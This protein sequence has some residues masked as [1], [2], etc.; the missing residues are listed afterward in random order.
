MVA[1]GIR[2]RFN[3]DLDAQIE[4]VQRANYERWA[5]LDRERLRFSVAWYHAASGQ[6]LEVEI[7]RFGHKVTFTSYPDIPK[8]KFTG[9]VLT[10]KQTG[11]DYIIEVGFIADGL[12]HAVWVSD[13]KWTYDKEYG[14]HI[15]LDK[16]K[17]KCRLYQQ[18]VVN[19]SKLPQ[20]FSELYGITVSIP[21]I[22][23][24]IK[25]YQDDGV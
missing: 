17:S 10:S 1:R 8:R 9:L 12:T 25:E 22:Q 5:V 18:L 20:I 23:Q 14:S 11:E 13:G 4:S 16:D 15:S 7:E 21:Q 6:W 19:I 24:A 3:N 2:K